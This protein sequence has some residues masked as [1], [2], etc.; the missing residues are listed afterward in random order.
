[1][2]IGAKMIAHHYYEVPHLISLLAIAGIIG[3]GVVASIVANRRAA[4]AAPAA[5]E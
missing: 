4:P 1:M 5:A 2:L 3:A